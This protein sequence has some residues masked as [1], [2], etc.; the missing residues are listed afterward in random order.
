MIPAISA[1]CMGIAAY[2][3]Y[4]GME[5]FMILT[6]ILQKDTMNWFLN[7]VCL[8]PAFLISVVI[9]FALILKLRAVSRKE[10]ESMPKGGVLVKV[11]SKMH[12]L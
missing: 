9:Y 2:L 5:W 1:V 8:A 4:K 3:V 12:L 7:C 10:L 11:A 6:G